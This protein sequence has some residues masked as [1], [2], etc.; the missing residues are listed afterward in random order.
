VAI[1]SR[2]TGADAAPFRNLPPDPWEKVRDLLA[3]A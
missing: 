2:M 3:A 1:F